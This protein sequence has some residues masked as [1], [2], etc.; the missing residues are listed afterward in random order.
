VYEPLL[1]HRAIPPHPYWP[2]GAVRLDDAGEPS[3][4]SLLDDL[5]A[6]AM[7]AAPTLGGDSPLPLQPRLGP[8]MRCESP[9]SCHR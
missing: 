3:A 8:R 4:V 7:R 6:E 2:G 1:V 9:N 5:S